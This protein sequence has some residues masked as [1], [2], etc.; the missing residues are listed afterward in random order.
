MPDVPSTNSSSLPATGSG[1]WI[2]VSLPNHTIQVKQDGDLVKEITNFATGRIGHLTPVL[3]EVPIDP[4]M[5]FVMHH[6]SAY[7]GAAMPYSLFFYEGCA[8]HE[9]NPAVESHGCVHLDAE[10]AKWLFDWVGK[11]AVNVQIQGPQRSGPHPGLGA[12]PDP[13]GAN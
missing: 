5:R 4:N 13:L 3:K 7:N 8:F 6:S 1:R 11:N 10:D 9:G 2:V 12:K